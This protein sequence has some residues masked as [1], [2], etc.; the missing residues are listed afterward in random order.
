MLACFARL[1][2]HT[3][4]CP[5]QTLRRRGF[6]FSLF[7]YL[8]EWGE[9]PEL[10]KDGLRRRILAVNLRRELDFLR[11]FVVGDRDH[12]GRCDSRFARRRSLRHSAIFR[13]ALQPRHREDQPHDEHREDPNHHADLLQFA[14]SPLY[15]EIP[16]TQDYDDADQCHDDRGGKLIEA[17]VRSIKVDGG[18]HVRAPT[19]FL[20]LFALI[21]L[22]ADVH[23]QDHAARIGKIIDQ[24]VNPLPSGFKGM[25]VAYL[26]SQ[27]PPV[28]KTYGIATTDG[29]V[30]LN[31]KTIFGVGSMTKL[32]AATLLGIANGAGLPLNT[33]ARTLLPPS[34]VIAPT[35]NRY[36]IKLQDL[37]DHHA[38]LPK[39]EGHLYPSLN[40]MYNYYA[41]DPITCNP[42]TSELI[43]DCGCCDSAYMSLLGVAPTCGTGV[44]NPVYTCKT[45]APTTGQAGWMYSNVGFEILGSTIATWM[46]YADWNTAN[47]QEITAPL[48]MPDTVPLESF[49]ANQIARAANHCSPATRAT[50]TNCQLLDW[51]PVGNAA[52]GLFSTA[53]DVLQFLAYN[54]YGTVGYGATATAPPARL[55]TALPIIHQPYERTNLGGN[56]ELGWQAFNITTGELQHWK[57]GSNGPFNSWVGYTT[58]PL[59]RMV[60][61]LDNSGASAADL[62]TIVTN[63]L[64]ATGASI[65]SVETANGG[66]D[67]AQNSWTVIKGNNLVPAN[68]P[69][70]GVI[71]STAPEF[72]QGK[73][74]TQLG[75]VSVTVDGKPAFI[76][77]YC[78][79]ATSPCASDQINVLTPLDSASGP[80][81]IVVT[82]G[83]VSSAPFTVN[84]KSVS[85]ALLLF[86]SS[87]VAATHL[88]G[89]LLAPATLYPGLSTPAKPGEQV[90][91]YGV[92]FGLPGG[93]LVNGSSSQSGSLPVLPVCKIGTG[94]AALNATLSFAGLISPGLYQLNLTVPVGAATGDDA[95]SCTYGGGSTPVG[96]VIAVQP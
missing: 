46:G 60:A 37:A 93:A 92:G 5:L 39:N 6:L 33:P 89:S 42:A 29:T 21:A 3:D 72:N 18:S 26:D 86:D 22:V 24:A 69:S 34:V 64:Q 44:A 38:G 43:H 68:A 96:A 84:L 71:W 19:S 75:G 83:T 82:N 67:I 7:E 12:H 28:Y 17:H 55:A 77:Y 51:L 15:S 95:I 47:L 56:Q 85:P 76:Y 2:P 52:G 62:G 53:S 32:F 40:D 13:N 35:Q 14:A 54:A 80:V 94:A 16:K 58:G 27:G 57:D 8:S 91:L 61:I 10:Q 63:I 30:P 70:T 36:A 11:Q 87:H 1:K 90:V 65:T 20:F 78:S 88:D 48:L 41:A 45:H 81:Q 50:N 59:T 79:A 4:R 23:A 9:Y 31:E 73:M 74:P 66:T 25:I 49:S